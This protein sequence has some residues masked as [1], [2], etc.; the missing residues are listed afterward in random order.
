VTDEGV[1]LNREQR[2]HAEWVEQRAAERLT[3]KAGGQESRQ[4]GQA[5]GD[6]RERQAGRR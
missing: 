3:E 6:R 5:G 1:P 4:A 2:Q